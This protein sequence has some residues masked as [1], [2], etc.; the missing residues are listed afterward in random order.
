MQLGLKSGAKVGTSSIRRKAQLLALR[1]DI[2]LVDI[3]GN[4]TEL[5]AYPMI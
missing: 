3:R 2:Q 5:S 1:P 4:T